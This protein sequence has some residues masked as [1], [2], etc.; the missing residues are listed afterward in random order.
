MELYKYKYVEA[1]GKTVL[2]P[3]VYKTPFI[4]SEE[5]PDNDY[6]LASTEEKSNYVIKTETSNYQERKRLG[7][8][9]SNIMDARLILLGKSIPD[10]TLSELIRSEVDDLFNASRFQVSLGR[11]IS[12][13]REIYKVV[14]SSTLQHAIDTY[15]IPLDQDVLIQEVKNYIDQKVVELYS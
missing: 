12:A 1:D 13:K 7:T 14:P 2:K 6:E 3:N 9:Y 5:A 10:A 11:W 15:S 8:E 4:W